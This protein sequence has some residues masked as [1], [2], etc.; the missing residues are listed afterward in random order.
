MLLCDEPTG[1]L[2]S[3][4]GVAVLEMLWNM[5]RKRG[6]TVIVVTHNAVLADVAD[7]VIRLRNGRVQ[8][9]AVNPSPQSIGGV[10]W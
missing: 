10:T 6:K 5:S 8:D 2:D 9:V 3:E 4:T 7:R 1:A